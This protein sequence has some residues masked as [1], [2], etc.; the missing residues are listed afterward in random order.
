MKRLL[1][2]LLVSLALAVGLSAQEAKPEAPVIRS[3][4]ACE[5]ELRTAKQVYFRQLAESGRV[6][7]MYSETTLQVLELQTQ[8]A[9]LRA[10]L[11]QLK[12]AAE[13]L[14]D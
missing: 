2:A 9:E 5:G 10:Q 7:T 3:L 4:E 6:Q 12:P 13:K 1:F 14:K 8:V 11:A